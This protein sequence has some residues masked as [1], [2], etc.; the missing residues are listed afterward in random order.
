MLQ[1]YPDARFVLTIRDEEEWYQ[2]MSAHMSDAL[3]RNA[4]ILPFRLRALHDL[5]YGTA[6][7]VKE[8]WLNHYRQHNQ[9]VQDVIPPEQLLVID[10]SKSWTYTE[11]CYFLEETEGPCADI[12][13]QF[14]AVNPKEERELAASNRRN[15][16]VLEVMPV[17]DKPLT[18]RAYVSLLAFPSDPKRRDYFISFLVA[19]DTIRSTGT[20]H[21]IV[22][23]VYGGIDKEDID[24]LVMEGIKYVHIAPIGVPL[25]PNPEAFDQTNAGIYRSKSRVLGL[26]M[27]EKI[28]YFDADVVFHENCDDLFNT[29]LA[30][31]GGD[32]GNSPFNAGFFIFTPSLQAMIDIND[33]ASTGEFDTTKGW[34]SY[35]PIPSWQNPGSGETT[36][37]SFYGASVEQGLFY[38]YLFLHQHG[39]GA[40]LVDSDMWDQ[41]RTHFTGFTKPFLNASKDIKNVPVR[42]RRGHQTWM[43][44]Y[45]IMIDRI[46]KRYEEQYAAALAASEQEE[47]YSDATDSILPTGKRIEEWNKTIHSTTQISTQ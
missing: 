27:Y 26:T 46:T 30:F 34:L 9:R 17:T 47:T 41:Q 8:T 6:D 20:E 4:G 43:D 24:L 5:V 31:P 37:W 32:G 38:Y 16:N 19:A 11:L 23:M 12:T 3:E 36:D 39:E 40:E 25:D 28:L 18:Q 45:H 44:H 42:F 29:D 13:V 7:D 21:D 22:A 1:L 15:P 14:P 10:V 35:G 2:S 33:I